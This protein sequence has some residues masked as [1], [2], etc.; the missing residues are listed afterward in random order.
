[1]K[2]TSLLSLLHISSPALPIGAFAYSQGLEYTLDAGWCKKA[3][4]VEQWIASV[5]KQGLAG[6]DLP[7]L[8]RM[9]QAW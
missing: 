2:T 5:L 7:I 1:M 4:D 3:D 8:K 6:V 9:H